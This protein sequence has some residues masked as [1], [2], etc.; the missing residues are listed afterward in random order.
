M[1][2]TKNVVTYEDFMKSADTKVNAKDLYPY[3]V[4][5][6]ATKFTGINRY[7]WGRYEVTPVQ[8]VERSA[9][10][11]YWDNLK[12]YFNGASLD[13]LCMI[14]TSG[15]MWS[16]PKGVAPIDVAISLGMYAAERAR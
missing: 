1:K 8:S 13:A 2:S 10:N 9:I 14:D 15:S 12:D 7:G 16:G 6:K 5:A 4:V 3:E 11:K